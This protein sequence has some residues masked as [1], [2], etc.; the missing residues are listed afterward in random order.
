MQD[1]YGGGNKVKRER[2]SIVHNLAG[3]CQ[4]Q[5]DAARAM[6]LWQESLELKDKIGDV[7]GKFQ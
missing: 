7:K 1:G 2:A 3:L 5:G 6:Q 4:Q